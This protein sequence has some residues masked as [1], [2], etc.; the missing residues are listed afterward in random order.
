M[1]RQGITN[2]PASIHARLL[3]KDRSLGRPPGESFKY[4]IIERFIARLATSHYRETFILKGALLYV[5]W[6][7]SLP[8][9]TK[10]IDLLGISDLSTEEVVNIIK[11]VCNQDVEPDGVE[12]NST[13]LR[14]VQLREGTNTPGVR[15]TFQGKLGTA[16]FPMQIDIG[17]GDQVTPGVLTINY[18]NL[19]GDMTASQLYGYPPETV[20]AEKLHAMVVLGSIN[21]RMKDFFDIW[22]LTQR[23]NFDGAI[24]QEAIINTFN[25]RYTDLPVDVPIALRQEFALQQKMQWKSFLGQYPKPYEELQDFTVVINYLQK[26]FSPLLLAIRNGYTF[27]ENWSSENNWEKASD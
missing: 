21:S 5:A 22:Y 23:F 10:D 6:G 9:P 13:T 26:F 17:Y 15:I 7:I 2:L 25:A 19:L 16:I 20:I 8:R 27:N 1:T 11:E 18:P 24:L 3:N 14:G 12:F 4:Y